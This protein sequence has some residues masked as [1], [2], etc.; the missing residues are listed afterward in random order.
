M[1]YLHNRS[2]LVSGDCVDLSYCPISGSKF[3]G[4]T[5]E[6]DQIANSLDPA[7]GEKK[8]LLLWG[9]PG[10]GKTRVA[11]RYRELFKHRYDAII[12][13]DASTLDSASDSFCQAAACIRA[14]L[15]SLSSTLATL[16]VGDKDEA[17]F[18]VRRWLE[19][20]CMN[21][22][23][24]VPLAIEQAGAFLSSGSAL[25]EFRKFYHE[26]YRRL[27]EERPCRSKW[28][29]DKNRSVF[30]TFE[31]LLAKLVSKDENATKILMLAAFLG[32][33]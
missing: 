31:M 17:V 30:D 5:R 23:D 21:L 2:R 4:R 22:V 18:L 16:T 12:W 27:M 11:L 6:L 9:L 14:R 33:G 8:R 32:P 24:G 15:P 26:N 19:H 20:D 1:L 25:Q 29:Y 28:Y 10:F 3:F 7:K 13:V